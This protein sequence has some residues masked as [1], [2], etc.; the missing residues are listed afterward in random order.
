MLSAC[1]YF[2]TERGLLVAAKSVHVEYVAAGSYMHIDAGSVESLELLRPLQLQPGGGGGAA[3]RKAG[4][5]FGYVT[6]QA[7]VMSFCTHWFRL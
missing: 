1:R 5:L 4:S 3:K 2:E 7:S 6:G